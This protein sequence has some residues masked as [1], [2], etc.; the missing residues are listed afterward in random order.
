MHPVELS[1]DAVDQQE[2]T[3]VNG[4]AATTSVWIPDSA[5]WAQRLVVD[6]RAATG[7]RLGITCTPRSR[8]RR[9]WPSPHR[10]GGP[11]VGQAQRPDYDPLAGATI[12]EPVHNSEGLLD[13]LSELPAT[14]NAALTAAQATVSR[15]LT[16]SKTA[17]AAATQRIRRAGRRRLQHSVR[18]QRAG[19]G[20][21]Q[22][23][24]R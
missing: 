5:T 3:L 13:L 1:S 15:L 7:P 12:P 16:V 24:T 11:A 20:R 14:G 10:Q 19:R 6:R 21:G 4:D 2:R 23:A 18:G 22:P 17:L 9:W 8:V